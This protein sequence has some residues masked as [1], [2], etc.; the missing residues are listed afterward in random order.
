MQFP[1]TFKRYIGDSKGVDVALGA[2]K[3]PTDR[4]TQEQ[5]NQIQFR[6]YNINGYPV[7]RVVIGYLGPEGP[8]P[9]ATVYMHEDSTGAWFQTDDTKQLRMNRFQYFDLPV[10]A[11]NANASHKSLGS[12]ELCIVVDKPKNAAEGIYT[13]VVG[14]DVSSPA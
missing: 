4:P 8:A 10:L 11:D 3:F 9:I 2:D 14:G 5:S 7:Q 1:K 12:I 13:F 6:P